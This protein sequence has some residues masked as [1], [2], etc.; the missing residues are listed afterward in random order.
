[1]GDDV[2]SVGGCS[3]P[4]TFLGA[5]QSPAPLK[6][7]QARVQQNKQMLTVAFSEVKGKV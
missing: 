1:M 5:D 2:D 4:R 7:F 3:E 6:N